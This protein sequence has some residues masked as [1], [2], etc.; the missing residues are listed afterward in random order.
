MG[1]NVLKRKTTPPKD[2]KTFGAP[3]PAA[4]AS[5]NGRTLVLCFDG[6]SNEFDG[7]NTNVVKLFSFLEK[8][9]PKQHVYYQVSSSFTVPMP[10]HSRFPRLA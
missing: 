7:T 4:P 10:Q 6:T 2:P 5:E 9:N 1:P 3:V 8:E